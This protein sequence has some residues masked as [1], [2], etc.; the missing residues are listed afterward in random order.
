[1]FDPQ[2]VIISAGFDAHA[3]ENRDIAHCE[4]Q[5]EDFEWATRAVQA[6]AARVQTRAGSDRPVPVVSILEG[7]YNVEAICRC[8]LLHCL[9]L[10]SELA[11]EQLL[12]PTLGQLNIDTSI[13]VVCEIRQQDSLELAGELQTV[14]E[15]C[16]T[17]VLSA[18]A[19]TLS[20]EEADAALAAMK[21]SL[22]RVCE[23]KRTRQAAAGDRGAW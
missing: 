4:L 10:A 6:A 2:L 12:V 8:A 18:E 16:C 17:L 11:G 1:M 7:G 3:D 22:L 20:G 5:D 15:L 14:N 13:A 9:A 21:S 23:H 19:G